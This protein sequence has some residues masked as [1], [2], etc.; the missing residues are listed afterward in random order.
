MK[1][2][3]IDPSSDYKERRL[4]AHAE[5]ID[6]ARAFISRLSVDAVRATEKVREK[7]NAVETAQRELVEAKADLN[8]IGSMMFI[9]KEKLA[10]LFEECFDM[11]NG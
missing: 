11:E 5:A 1:K 2:V 10:R 9:Q 3:T 6:E 7:N 8:R 4:R